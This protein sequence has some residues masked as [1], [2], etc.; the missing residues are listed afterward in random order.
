[1]EVHAH[2]HT[3]RKKW[4]HYFWEF[5]MLFLAVFC[6]FLAEYQLEHKIENDRA[7]EFAKLLKQD[8]VNDTLLLNNLNKLLSDE[9]GRKQ[10]AEEILEKELESITIRD[11]RHVDTIH[12]LVDF[13]ISKNVTFEQM[14]HAGQ[15][16]YF[17]NVNLSAAL[18]DYD[19]SVKHYHEMKTNIQNIY[20]GLSSEHALQSKITRQHFLRKVEG[21]S[22]S[23]SAMKEGYK[24]ESWFENREIQAARFFLSDFLM[25]GIY[26]DLKVQ[27]TNIINILNKEYHL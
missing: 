25:Q 24:F 3:A 10:F 6:G 11:L 17:Q 18:G 7:K 26:P 27:A 9:S 8:L 12:F 23:L 21:R 19:W 15:L 22:D 13:F 16:R 5:L 2:T 4:T 1:M 20:G 14:K